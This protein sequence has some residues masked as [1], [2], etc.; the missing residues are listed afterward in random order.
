MDKIE[1]L[2]SKLDEARDRLQNVLDGYEARRAAILHEAFSGKWTGDS[3]EQSDIKRLP[4]KSVEFGTVV[5][6]QANP[7][8]NI[9]LTDQL[10]GLLP[11]I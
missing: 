2:F 7:I 8:R 3:G 4:L 6:H 5:V 1:T 10:C 9:G 11:K